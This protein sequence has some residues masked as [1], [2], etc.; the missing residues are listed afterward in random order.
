[1]KFGT[2]AFA[3]M[4]A[5]TC[6]LSMQLNAEPGP[7]ERWLMDEP[8]SLWDRGMDAM[9]ESTRIAY[10]AISEKHD[11]DAATN[12]PRLSYD[13]D[14]NEIEIEM[15]LVRKEGWAFPLMTHGACNKVR[16][17]AIIWIVGYGTAV[18]LGISRSSYDTIVK[19]HAPLQIASWFSHRGFSRT[20]RDMELEEKLAE[21]IFV[22]VTMRK[23][24][25]RATEIFG[26]GDGISCRDRITSL[27]APSRPLQFEIETLDSP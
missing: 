14:R 21:I 6:P 2:T 19:D 12:S 25:T 3:A 22:E 27:E 18:E 26:Q 13:W 23:P 8:V 16:A 20:S 17:D 7:I 24:Y 5:W 15:V 1:M 4:M 11:L 9:E 10:Q